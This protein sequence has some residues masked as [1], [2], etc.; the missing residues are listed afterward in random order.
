MS[1]SEISQTHEGPPGRSRGALATGA[2]AA[3]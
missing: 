3:T 2:T 1:E